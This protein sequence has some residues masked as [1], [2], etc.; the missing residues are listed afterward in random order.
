MPLVRIEAGWGRRRWVGG[1]G[2]NG[3]E[4][5]GECNDDTNVLCASTYPLVS[6]TK[7]IIG[8]SSSANDRRSC[9]LHSFEK[10][11]MPLLQ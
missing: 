10:G 1:K 5:G 7:F 2:C 3:Q 9:S 8:S 4:E 11:Y 6:L